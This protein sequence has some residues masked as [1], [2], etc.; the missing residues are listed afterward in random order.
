MKEFLELG[1]AE[2]SNTQA[3]GVVEFGARLNP[4]DDKI[5]TLADAGGHTTA[6]I[7]YASF[8]LVPTKLLESPG[9]YE[10]PSFEGSLLRT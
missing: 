4:R 1:F 9:E 2:Y 8:G 7:F 5:R 10:N 6:E 3:L